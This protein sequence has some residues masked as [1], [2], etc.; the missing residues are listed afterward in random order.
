MEV[1]FKILKR[2]WATLNKRR[3]G[4]YIGLVVHEPGDT[5]T[6]LRFAD[7][8]LLVACSQVDI[9][10][11]ITDLAA[12]A[13]KYGLKLHMGKTKV[14]TNCTARRPSHID[15]CGHPVKI[16]EPGEAERYLGRKL[17]TACFH[18][19][20][21]QN[22]LA[23]GWACFF[24]L[25]DTLCNRRLPLKDRLR[26]FEACVTPC[27]LY[28][29]STWTMTVQ[30][31][32]LLNTARRRMLRWM[33]RI[34]KRPEEEWG[35]FISRATH[36]SE[37]LAAKHGLSNWVVT[38]RLR[39]FECACKAAG[40]KDGR[41]THLL[42]SWRPWFRCIPRRCVGHPTRRW[43]DD[44]VAFAGGNWHRDLTDQDL[45]AASLNGFIDAKGQIWRHHSYSGF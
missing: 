8:V 24:R 38:Q 6:N 3:K 26:L 12:E 36:A 17:S 44:L 42:L 1:I 43:C 37:D 20:E 39:K 4:Q 14:L 40:R 45:A 31:E 41:W 32:T 2:R 11:M 30:R 21:L 35:S 29:C 33:C 23:C 16:L 18:E 28:A 22:R 13:S 5:L 15:C 10:K 25:K 27:V 34:P 7:D 9:K 19:V